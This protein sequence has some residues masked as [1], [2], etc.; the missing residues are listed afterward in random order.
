MLKK[1]SDKTARQTFSQSID[2]NKA[3]EGHVAPVTQEA[4][5]VVI[6]VK[7]NQHGVERLLDSLFDGGESTYPLEVILVDNNSPEPLRI[8]ER[9]RNTASVRLLKCAKPGAAA[10]RNVGAAAARG[11]WILFTDSDCIPT[12]SFV[13][14]Y[15]SVSGQAIAYAGNVQGTPS[16]SLT[17][18]YDTERTLLPRLKTTAAGVEAPLYV[19]T[20]NA[21]IWKK[22][23]DLCG[24]FDETFDGA[25]GEDVELSMRLWR[26]G[27]IGVALNS[28]VKHDFDDGVLG[29]WRRYKRYG[30]GNRTLEDVAGIAMRPRWRSSARRGSAGLRFRL[31]KHAALCYGYYYASQR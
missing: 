20:A 2:V 12:S 27:G 21:L 19:V 3:Y 5:S 14:G 8:P 30:R 15:T 31:I 1:R 22:A 13:R 11:E 28:V 10:A 4:I 9:H 18:F 23:F 6:P 25:G 16:N 24:G 7:G 29:L 17:R 26:I